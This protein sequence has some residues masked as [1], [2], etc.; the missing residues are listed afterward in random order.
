MKLTQ[1]LTMFFLFACGIFTSCEYKPEGDYF[2]DLHPRSPGD[3]EIAIT[4]QSDTVVAKD[5]RSYEVRVTGLNRSVLFHRLYI[6]GVEKY[7][8]NSSNNFFIDPLSYI[9][10][11]GIYAVTVEV[12]INTGSGS[13]GDVLHT[14]GYLYQKEFVLVVM[15]EQI[16]FYPYVKFD[17]SGNRMKIYL[18]VP[19]HVTNIRKVVFSKFVGN[20]QGDV[21]ATSLGTS[22]FE[23]YDPQYVGESANYHLQTYIGDQSG[24][25]FYPFITGGEY[26]ASDHPVLTVGSSER[27]FPLL[28]WEKSHYASNCGGYRIYGKKSGSGEFTHLASITGISD[29][30]FE[31]AGTEFPTYYEF[32]VAPV[33][34]QIPSWFTDQ[35]A[36][37][38]YA[39][40]I[41]TYVGMNSFYF[42]RF[43]SPD[44]PYVYY[45]GNSDEIYE[46]NV[47][48][49]ETTDIITAAS[50]WF[51]TFSVSPNGK[52]LL[53]ATGIR[54]FSYLFY[55][56]TT[57]QSTW[58]PSSQVLGAGAETGITSIADNG[59]ASIISGTRMVVHDFLHQSPVT[60]Q[61]FP[62]IGNRSVI[63]ADGQYIFAEA[64]NLYL[65]KLT[66]NI[67]TQKWIS[68]SQPGTF[69]YY[70]FEPSRPSKAKIQ[71]DQTLFTKDCETWNTEGSYNPAFNSICN[72]DFANGHILGK[73]DTHFRV[74]DLNTGTLQFENPTLPSIYTTDLRIKKNTVYHS[75]GKKLNIFP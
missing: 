26:A 64:T 72:I 12:G 73:T 74:L 33:P 30:T 25:Y 9:Q 49:G 38:S 2:L 65:Y 35:V 71:I 51:Y 29:T 37:D 69:K 70:N 42:N 41:T 5:A 14:E 40:N 63:S 68:S 31:A 22:H 1:L 36:W 13:I 11:D 39:G 61:V 32:R 58:I 16:S 52:Y 28:T 59:L 55:D 67:L 3:I 10:K 54:D 43:L 6:N 75:S 53:A 19:S 21:F 15:R 66:G 60:Q 48:T 45:T 62:V 24:T 20:S 50:G 57:N 46:Y 8:Q 44:G 18:D 34:A 56:L 4:G 23:A 17:R 7:L 27:G 47:E